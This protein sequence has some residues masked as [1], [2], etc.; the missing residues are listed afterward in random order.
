MMKPEYP[1]IDRYAATGKCCREIQSAIGKISGTETFSP[2][3]RRSNSSGASFHLN[4]RKITRA[5]K[6]C[7]SFDAQQRLDQG[8]TARWG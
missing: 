6:S 4:F 2:A 1:P 8:L 3:A 5:D 7:P